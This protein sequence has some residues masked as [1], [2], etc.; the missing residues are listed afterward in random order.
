MNNTPTQ[1]SKQGRG[2]PKSESA[3]SGQLRSKELR[4]RRK[5]EAEHFAH[6]VD[7]AVERY[8]AIP[9]QELCA[10]IDKYSS[11][12]GLHHKSVQDRVRVLARKCGVI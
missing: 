1:P 10:D 3:K 4:Q 7:V 6:Q 12:W 5:Q 9:I 11:R 8:G 2:R